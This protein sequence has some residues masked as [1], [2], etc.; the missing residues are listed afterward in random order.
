VDRLSFES[1]EIL[2]LQRYRH[3]LVQMRTK[4]KNSLQA[5]S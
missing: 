5:R 4:C 1:R 3:R 2:R